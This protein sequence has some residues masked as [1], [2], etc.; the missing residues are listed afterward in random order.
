MTPKYYFR[1][2]DPVKIDGKSYDSILAMSGSSL[3]LLGGTFMKNY[4]SIHDNANSR[5]GFAPSK[6]STARIE[7]STPVP[8]TKATPEV[9]YTIFNYLWVYLVEC[10]VI[11]GLFTGYYYLFF[12]GLI[13]WE[14]LL[15]KDEA[16][17]RKLQKKVKK[18]ESDEYSA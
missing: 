9:M 2:I 7:N 13:D 4:Y 8:E 16:K 17:R 15:G 3:F 11:G 1:P 5:I 10:C 18:G 14:A 12:A 6:T